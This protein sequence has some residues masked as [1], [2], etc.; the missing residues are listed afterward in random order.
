M[1]SGL[2]QGHAGVDQQN[3][4][5]NDDNFSNDNGNNMLSVA[6]VIFSAK[7]C[8]MVGACNICSLAGRNGKLTGPLGRND[9]PV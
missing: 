3:D 5:T 4:D 8:T 6:V 9:S 7:S 1:E 2:G